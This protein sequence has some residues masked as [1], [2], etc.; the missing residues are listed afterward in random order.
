MAKLRELLQQSSPRHQPAQ[1]S[2]DARD[3]QQSPQAAFRALPLE[4]RLRKVERWSML[5]PSDLDAALEGLPPDVRVEIKSRMGQATAARCSL[6]I[7]KV[8][9]GCPLLA[10]PSLSACRASV[11]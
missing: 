1:R 2:S 9:A 5:Q 11:D 6:N 10:E 8:T 4:Q 7:Q 3:P